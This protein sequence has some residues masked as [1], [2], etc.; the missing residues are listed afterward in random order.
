MSGRSAYF[1]NARA[2]L[3]WLVVLGHCLE[4]V[5][6]DTAVDG[7]YTLIYSFHM[8]VFAFLSG[9]CSKPDAARRH[10][11]Q[12]FFWMAVAT[13]VCELIEF[14]I[15]GHISRYT[16]SGYPYW[17]LWWLWSL[18]I[19]RVTLP[20][21]GRTVWSIPMT[22]VL[23]LAV[24]AFFPDGYFLGIARTT[25]FWPFFLAGFFYRDTWLRLR[26]HA[27][28][29]LSSIVLLVTAILLHVA[30]IPVEILYGSYTAPALFLDAGTMAGFRLQNYILASMA[31][32]AVLAVVP[33]SAS[34]ITRF[35]Q[36][37]LWVF[38]GHV[39]ILR[40][41]PVKPLLMAVDGGI[42]RIVL[43]ALSAGAMVFLLSGFW[44][45]RSPQSVM[46]G[47]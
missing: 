4:Q 47:P 9:A 32:M 31:G 19:W 43:C 18:G 1:D 33:H 23:A 17:A 39:L 11:V 3:I 13:L 5:R 14:L 12:A 25:T 34:W 24:G 35:G 46:D 27:K 15:H 28:P 44:R 2:V 36:R 16:A 20:L 10:G 6:V 45:G 22:L 41:L 29:G 26:G 38:L 42:S 7:L 37:T 30:A 8:P 21:L 40:F